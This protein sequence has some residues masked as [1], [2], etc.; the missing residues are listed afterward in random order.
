MFATFSNFER[1]ITIKIVGIVM[2]ETNYNEVKITYDDNSFIVFEN[3]IID[4][5]QGSV[6]EAL[7]RM[8]EERW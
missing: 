7:I 2:V 8:I 3:F 4:N 5:L 1:S 6:Y